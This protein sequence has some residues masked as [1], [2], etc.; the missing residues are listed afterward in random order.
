MDQAERD[1]ENTPKI[2]LVLYKTNNKKFLVI[3]D[4]E[5][6]LPILAEHK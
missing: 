1:S 3:A 6:I 4:A 2:P 5:L